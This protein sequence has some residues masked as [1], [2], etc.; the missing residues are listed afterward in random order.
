MSSK[1][2]PARSAPP[3]STIPRKIQP[4]PMLYA[5]T[6]PQ[7]MPGYE[8][9]I[10]VEAALKGG[11]QLVQYRNKNNSD[12][13]VTAA[14][15]LKQLCHQYHAQLIVND[16]IELAHAIAADGVHL[17]QEDESL[18]R[19]RQRLGPK[20]IIGITCHH[21]LELA[22]NAEA[23]G[24]SYVAF[25]RF[26][27]SNTKPDAQQAPLTILQ[28]ARQKISIPIVAIGGICLDNSQQIIQ[29]GANSIAVCHGLFAQQDITKTAYDFQSMLS[30]TPIPH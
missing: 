12:D 30:V 28:Q 26:F 20:A 9:F 6:D 17:G 27:N 11:C 16:D 10:K 8:L 4:L 24:A 18:Q 29:A 3:P 1:I 5:I 7:L 25:G 22:Q 13:H 2:P 14:R 21:S 23:T 15:A 19:A